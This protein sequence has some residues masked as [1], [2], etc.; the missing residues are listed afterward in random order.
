VLHITWTKVIDNGA[1]RRP[2]L[3]GP[4]VDKAGATLAV[5][6]QD[7]D[8]GAGESGANRPPLAVSLTL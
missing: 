8:I 7:L 2:D 5:F 1:G 3:R 6:G 4:A